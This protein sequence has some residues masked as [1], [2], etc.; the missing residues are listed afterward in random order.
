MQ[1]SR[2]KGSFKVEDILTVL[3]KDPKKYSRV[4]DL[5]MKSNRITK[6]RDSA[7]YSIKTAEG[8]IDDNGKKIVAAPKQKASSQANGAQTGTRAKKAKK[9]KAKKE[10]KSTK[11]PIIRRVKMNGNP[12]RIDKT[13]K[14]KAKAKATGS[15]RKDRD[16]HP[17]ATKKRKVGNTPDS[18]VVAKEK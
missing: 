5:L 10:K 3:R 6:A 14:K 18:E 2:R 7:N 8:K 12:V 13:H 16:G 9:K 1:V 15:K 11:T 4:K 17:G